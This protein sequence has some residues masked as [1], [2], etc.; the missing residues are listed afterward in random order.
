MTDKKRVPTPQ[1]GQTRI[2]SR[3]GFSH[4]QTPR[5]QPINEERARV[6]PRDQLTPPPP[7]PRKKG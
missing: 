6:M 5:R 3:D 4:D 7:I 1:P 2:P